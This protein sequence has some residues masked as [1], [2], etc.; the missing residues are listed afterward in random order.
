MNRR[1]KWNWPMPYIRKACRL[2]LTVC[3]TFFLSYPGPL[4]QYSITVPIYD[5][6]KV[7]GWSF[8]PKELQ[9]I[10]KLPR[11]KNGNADPIANT[12]VA[13]VGYTAG[14]FVS[15]AAKFQA[16]ARASITTNVM[17]VVILG[18]MEKD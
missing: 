4:T 16:K 15:T 2:K 6:R 1:R 18:R 9:D 17:F 8:R 13:T 14:T 11:F 3:H 5:A 12:Y 7:K 10:S